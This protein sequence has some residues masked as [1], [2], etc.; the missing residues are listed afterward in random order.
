MSKQVYT[1]GIFDS[2]ETLRRMYN[3]EVTAA[4]LAARDDDSATLRD[5]M[6]SMETLNNAI[7]KLC[8]LVSGGV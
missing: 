4:E 6:A 3:Q 1:D 2:M 5:H 8:D 7:L